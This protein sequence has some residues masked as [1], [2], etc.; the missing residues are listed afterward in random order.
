MDY[1]QPPVEH[2]VIYKGPNLI[3]RY[4]GSP[5]EKGWYHVVMEEGY[6]IYIAYCYYNGTNWEEGKF[7]SGP[8]VFFW[9]DCPYNLGK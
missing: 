1:Q 9:Q 6:K 5:K 3:S 2:K 4:D 7:G 8:E